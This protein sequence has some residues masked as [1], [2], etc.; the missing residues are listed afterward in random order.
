MFLIIL[1]N[2]YPTKS[3]FL[4]FDNFTNTRWSGQNVKSPTW[5][6]SVLCYFTFSQL[7]FLTPHQSVLGDKSSQTEN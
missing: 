4:K 6:A 5:I 7:S 2:E 1:Y 3:T